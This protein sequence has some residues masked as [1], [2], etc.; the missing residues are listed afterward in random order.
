[1][2]LE[3]IPQIVFRP[4]KAGLQKFYGKLEAELLDIIWENG[5]MTVKRALYFAGQKHPYA[6]TTVMT[7]MNHLVNKGILTREK[8][9]HSFLYSP[10]MTKDE[11]LNLAIEKIVA[12]LVGDFESPTRSILARHTP[13]KGKKLK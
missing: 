7:V 10:V 8:V 9:S 12:G 4:E 1:M 2:A 6:Y 13:P 3:K 5:P 11:F